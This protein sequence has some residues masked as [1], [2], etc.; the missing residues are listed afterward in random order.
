MAKRHY[1]KTPTK[2]NGKSLKEYDQWNQMRQRCREGYQL[3][4]PT[5]AGCHLAPEWESYDNW[6]EWAKQQKGFLQFDEQGRIYH[7]DKDLLV[8]GNRA[9]A[10]DQC[11][12][13]PQHLNAFLNSHSRA[14]GKLPQGLCQHSKNHVRVY[15][16]IN[17]KQESLG[18]FTNPDE[19]YRVYAEAKQAY[20]KLLAE[21]YDGLVDSRV[22]SAL[23]NFKL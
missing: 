10:P 6:L 8:K 13:V 16:S 4:F 23:L 17:G 21:R 1:W 7:I 12:F 5:Y 11:V 22:I 19:A 20:A 18:L 15:I 3:K 9:Y 2:L 14:R